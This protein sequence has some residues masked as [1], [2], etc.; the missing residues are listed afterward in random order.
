[1]IRRRSRPSI[2]QFLL[3]RMPFIRKMAWRLGRKLYTL[4]RGDVPNNPLTNG[5]YWLLEQV[6]T[7]TPGHKVLFDVGANRGD[8][9]GQATALAGRSQEISVHAFEPSKATRAI[10]T[11]RFDSNPLITVHPVALSDKRGIA[12]FYSAGAGAGTSSLSPVSGPTEENVVVTTIDQLLKDMMLQRV[13]MLKVDTEGF[14]FRVLCGAEHSLANGVI[15]VVQFEYNW[16]WL[17]NHSSLRDVFELIANKP[18]RL[19]KLV[20]NIIEFYDAWHFELD[21]YFESNY[22][23]VRNGF[24]LSVGGTRAVFDLTDAPIKSKS[25]DSA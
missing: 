11:N 8:W 23:L 14:D 9:T 16:R 25:W 6:L 4:A 7:S 5:E 19:G 17:L 18:Y 13:S 22:V 21:R 12:A 10:L 2:G 20:G 15:D 3:Y 1:M 24:T